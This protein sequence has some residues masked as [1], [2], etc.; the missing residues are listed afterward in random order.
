[1]TGTAASEGLTLGMGVDYS[2][3]LYGDAMAT[4]ILF[5]PAFLK[6]EHDPWTAKMS[7]AYVRIRGPGRV[8][9]N[10]EKPI[11]ADESAQGATT[12]EGLGDVT[13]ALG[14]TLWTDPAT[15]MGL[16][17][18]AKLKL[19]TADE[20]KGLGT[21]KTDAGLLLDG[22]AAL[23]PVSWIAGVGYRWMGDPPG[24]SYRNVWSGNTGFSLKAGPTVSVGL[25]YDYRQSVYATSPGSSELT[26]FASF[27]LGRGYKLQWYGTVG[28]SDSSPDRGMGLM[29]Q[30]GF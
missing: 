30:H 26:P 17:L 16:D 6:W 5:V 19:P 1:M 8:V 25:M 2:T 24:S 29:L 22:Y 27:K 13:L 10:G 23:G 14:R 21:G 12:E 11:Q 3:G 28:L 15:G 7:V 20:T 4:D 18:T 9:L